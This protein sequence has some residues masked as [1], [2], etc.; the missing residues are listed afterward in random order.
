MN[1]NFM[2]QL[3][4]LAQMID[5]LDVYKTASMNPDTLSSVEYDVKK[6]AD[7]KFE[8]SVHV[9]ANFPL[10]SLT[11]ISDLSD[12]GDEIQDQ[13]EDC[14][15]QL[16]SDCKIKEFK[17]LVET[18]NLMGHFVYELAL[19][20]DEDLESKLEDCFGKAVT[21]KTASVS[22]VSRL[23]KNKYASK[24]FFLDMSDYTANKTQFVGE[25]L[26][27][28]LMALYYST[29]KLFSAVENSNASAKSREVTIPLTLDKN[30][31]MGMLGMAMKELFARVY[32]S[33]VS[34]SSVK[35]HLETI[36]NNFNKVYY[37]AKEFND[38]MA[39]G[40][41]NMAAGTEAW[42]ML[43]APLDNFNKLL[44]EAEKALST[45]KPKP[46]YKAPAP[47]KPAP[48]KPERTFA[49][50]MADTYLS[51]LQEGYSPEQI[52][53]SVTSPDEISAFKD[54]LEEYSGGEV[55]E[56]QVQQLLGS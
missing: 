13:I 23:Y 50:T 14:L 56:E 6:L 32:E 45:F 25:P 31:A 2:T 21:K 43:S 33:D 5:E 38:P 8:L 16:S 15:K 28:S 51:Y 44:T 27:K 54:A 53:T 47:V 37:M 10:D 42:G 49:P 26:F 29:E 52:G 39:M 1:R 18:G 40:P 7:D 22:D 24:M 48:A 3:N 11:K 41:E 12:K 55:Q 30:S 35:R 34:P 36:R 17:A 4:K 46:K 20:S 19:E 9:K